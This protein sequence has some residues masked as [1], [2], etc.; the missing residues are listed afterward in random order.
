MA[1]RVAFASSNEKV[2]NQHF[3]RVKKYLIFEIDENKA[4]YVEVRKNKLPSQG[5][6]QTEKVINRTVNLISDCKAVFVT[7]IGYGALTILHEK[8]IKAFEVNDYIGDIIGK[9]L[10]AAIQI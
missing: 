3:G 4:E 8:G 1:F 6:E 10:S 5:F 9:I 7:A 2:V